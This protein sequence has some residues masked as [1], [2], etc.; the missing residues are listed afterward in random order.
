MPCPHGDMVVILATHRMSSGFS[1]SFP[2]VTSAPLS[3]MVGRARRSPS[4]TPRGRYCD[5]KGWGVCPCS[6]GG[7]PA[8]SA[9]SP[10]HVLR[11]PPKCAILRAEDELGRMTWDGWAPCLLHVPLLLW[12]PD[13]SAPG[14]CAGWCAQCLGW[15]R[16]PL[17]SMRQ[18]VTV[19][20]GGWQWLAADVSLCGA[21]GLAF[22]YRLSQVILFKLVFEKPKNQ[23]WLA[24]GCSRRGGCR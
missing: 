23:I 5:Q 7:E 11:V 24:S 16:G 13:Q 6:Y 20:A 3:T 10:K 9:P 14:I 2:S 15:P 17:L 1:S 4:Q 8:T 22:F 18:S 12:S 19:Q 21:V